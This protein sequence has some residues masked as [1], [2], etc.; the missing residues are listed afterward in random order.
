MTLGPSLQKLLQIAS[1]PIAQAAPVLSMT[2]RK[3]AGP[4]EEEL[5]EM[6][7]ERNGFYAFE[8]AL[9][10]LPAAPVEGERDLESWNAPDLWRSFYQEMADRC[11]FFAEDVFGFPF[12]IRDGKVA[13]MDAERG[14]IEEMASSLE[15]WA[16]IVLDDYEVQTGQPLAHQWQT[17]RGSI[18]TSSRLFPKTPFTLG[19]EYELE[20]LAECDA[21]DAM[22][23]RGHLA[24]QIKGVPPGTQIRFKVVD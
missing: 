15:E 5:T 1:P 8:S 14:E 6:L 10:V 7:R 21:V 19:G 2:S 12:L 20:N 9:H 18:P 17:M 22:R 16:K 11:L 3:L 4:L 13:S 24:Q 23:F